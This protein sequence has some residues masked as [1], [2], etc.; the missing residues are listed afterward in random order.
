MHLSRQ[1]PLRS[2]HQT[3][4]HCHESELCETNIPGVLLP[5]EPTQYPLGPGAGGVRTQGQDIAAREGWYWYLA[6]HLA[7]K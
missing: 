7:E 2:R 4:A 6:I 1:E 5:R 3:Q